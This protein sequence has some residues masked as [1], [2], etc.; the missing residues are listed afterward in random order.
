MSR[1]Y[2]LG[3]IGTG[4][5]GGA[6]VRGFVQRGVLSAAE[7]L[8]ADARAEAVETLAVATGVHAAQSNTQVVSEAGSVLVALKPQILPEV[9]PG[10]PWEPEQLVISIAAGVNLERLQGLTATGQPIVRVM[11]NILATVAEAAS[12]YA[13]NDQVTAT[14]LEFAERLLASVGVA[15]SVPERLLDAV[16]GLSG[17]GPAFVATFLEG[18]VDG[19]IAAGLPRADALRLAAQ[20]VLGVGRWVLAT[21]GSPAQLREQVTSPGGTTIA[22]LRAL[23]AGGLRSATMEAVVA[24]AQRSQQLGGG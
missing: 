3:V 1:Q 23:E 14:Q 4:A 17:S 8:V 16:T 24:A 6:L 21:G 11:P 19:G 9:L 10:L 2:K 5:M 20:T 22:G 18:L 13:H 7:I 15:V 12:A